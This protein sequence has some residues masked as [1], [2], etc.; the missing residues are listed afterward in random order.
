M[1]TRALA[2]YPYG[3]LNGIGLLLF[4]AVW[5]GV[6]FWIRRPTSTKLYESVDKMPLED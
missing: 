4:M 5:L 3:F 2:H 1:L 6:V